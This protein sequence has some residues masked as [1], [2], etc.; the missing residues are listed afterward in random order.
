MKIKYFLF[1]TFISFYFISCDTNSTD[2]EEITKEKLSKEQQLKQLY[3]TIVK[4]MFKAYKSTNIPTTFTVDTKDHSINAGSAHNYL[5]VSQGLVNSK[6]KHLQIYVLTHELSHIV[7]LKQAELFGLKG[8]IP[9]GKK[10]NDY[11]KS[12]YLADLIAVHLINTHQPKQLDLLRKDFSFLKE[13]LGKGD[14][15]HPS[16]VERIEMMQTYMNES[17]KK[18]P[19]FVFESFFKQIWYME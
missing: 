13:L 12:E 17:S 5:E 9:R 4:P 14:F 8:A 3:T 18:T 15:M 1:F 11:K 16:G 7:T 2:K 19:L 10:T 6:K